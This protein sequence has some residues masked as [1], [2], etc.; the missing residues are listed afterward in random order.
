MAK[1][2]ES[3]LIGGEDVEIIVVDDGSTDGTARIADDYAAKYPTIVKAVHKENGGH[4]DAVCAG[5]AHATG[6]YFKVVDSDDWLDKRAYPKVLAT[7]KGVIERGEDLDLLI[8]NYIYDKVGRRYKRVMRYDG[9]LPENEIIT[10]EDERIRLKMDQYVLMHSVIYKTEVLHACKLEL[11]KHTFYVDNIYVCKPMLF[12]KTLMY[13]NVDLYHYFI[14]REGQSVNEQ[15]MIKRI[16]QQLLVDRILIEFLSENKPEIKNLYKFLFKYLDM[17]M[18]VTSSICLAG[19][20]KELLQKRKDIWAF[21]KET[22]KDLY[23]ELKKSF[24]GVTMNLPGPV[25]RFFSRTGYRITQ[26]LFGFN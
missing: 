19:K 11:P 9:G 15:T 14:G 21:A 12:V 4:G 8:S 26:K 10:W 24:L 25:G 18:C 13:L 3:A 16:D 22:D 7:L 6:K 2:I 20:T 23:K 5:I 17:M 1:C